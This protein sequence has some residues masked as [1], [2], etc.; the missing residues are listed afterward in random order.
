[1]NRDYETEMADVDQPSRPLV[2]WWQPEIGAAIGGIVEFIGPMETSF[3]T[4]SVLRLR[5]QTGELYARNINS[6]LQTELDQNSV[7]IGDEIGLKFLGKR[8]NK[9]G[10][11]SY[12]LYAIRVFERA[13]TDQSSTS[14]QVDDV[15]F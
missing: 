14:D 3:G 12:N 13:K 6:A 11:R 5:D 10:D 2:T 15:P 4:G 7:H 9:T 1:M 8:Q